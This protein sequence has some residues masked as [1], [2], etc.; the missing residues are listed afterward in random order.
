MEEEPKKTR[1]DEI[2]SKL[3]GKEG[4][5]EEI[6]L[7]APSKDM[8]SVY[9]KNTNLFLEKLGKYMDEFE[10]LIEQYEDYRRMLIVQKVLQLIDSYEPLLF[11]I[12]QE[13]DFL[14]SKLRS[15]VGIK[16]KEDKKAE[17]QASTP[18]GKKDLSISSL[19]KAGM[20]LRDI[21][22]QLGMS[23]QMVKLK[24]KEMEDESKEEKIED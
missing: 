6:D 5:V 20:S 8:L 23:H 13:K 16:I 10:M 21:G 7:D 4:E 17:K 24:L 12:R 15:V 1:Y 11:N 22:D 3:E 2:R 9:E 14:F 18:E 19:R